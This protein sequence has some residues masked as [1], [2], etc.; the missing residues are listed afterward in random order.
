VYTLN[1]LASDLGEASRS[2]G[3]QVRKVVK[4]GAQNVKEDAKRN[5]LISAPIHNAHAAEGINYDVAEDGMSAE[6]GYDKR[7]RGARL[8]NVLEYGSRNNAPHRDLG[9]ALD[10]EEPRFEQ[11][12][13]DAAKK[14][15]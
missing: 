7:R 9:R 13:S 12:V 8:G 5:V 11:A 10:V 1:D 14:L 15:L 3:E 2:A 6:I 4:K